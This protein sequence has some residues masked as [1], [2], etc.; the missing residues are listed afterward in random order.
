MNRFSRI[1]MI[2]SAVLVVAVVGTIAYNAGIAS[3]IEQS[4]K[5]VVAAPA[6]PAPYPYP[7]YVWHGPWGG[8][9][10]LVPFFLIAVWIALALFNGRLNARPVAVRAT[11]ARGLL[12]AIGSGVVFYLIS[13]IWFPFNPRGWDYLLHFAGWTAA[14]FSGFA[15]LLLRR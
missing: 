14:Y 6:A 12:A 9:G 15:A 11:V 3:G 8:G 13:G 7:V 1:A 5:L 2:A 4:G 10:F